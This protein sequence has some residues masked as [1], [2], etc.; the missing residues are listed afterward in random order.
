MGS[1]SLKRLRWFAA[2]AAVGAACLVSGVTRAAETD[3]PEGVAPFDDMVLSVITENDAFFSGTDRNYTNGLKFTFSFPERKTPEFAR[4]LAHELFDSEDR[5]QTLFA[6]S[7]GHNIYTPED[8][9]A[10]M[11]LPDEHPYAGWLYIGGSVASIEAKHAD[12]LSIDLGVVGPAAQGEYVQS[13][14]HKMI[15]GQNPNGWDNQLKNEPGL[16]V[17]YERHWRGKSFDMGPLEFDITPMIGASLGNIQI[18]GSGGLGFRLGDNLEA[19]PFGPPRIRPS[20]SGP[21]TF[22]PGKFAWYFFVSTNGRA[23]AHDI[24]LDGNTFRTSQRVD[25]QALVGEIQAGFVVQVQRLELTYS[26]VSRTEQFEG[27]DDGQRFGAISLS[28]KL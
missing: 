22:G 26:V 17:S 2:L 27:Q 12:V 9:S 4:K 23:V 10:S 15:D 7:L 19:D 25:K 5:K 20:L 11:P 24:F 8:I 1:G 28:F 14:F 18:A 6:L 16:L 13:N 3:T 21:G